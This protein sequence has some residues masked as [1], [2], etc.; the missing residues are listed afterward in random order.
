MSAQNANL[1]TGLQDENGTRYAT[2]THDWVGHATGSSLNGGVGSYSFSFPSDTARTIVDPLGVSRT[3]AVAKVTGHLRYTASP[4]VCGGCNEASS[5]SYDAY[6]NLA[7]STDFN[8]HVSTYAYDTTRSLETSRTE[9]SGTS[10]AR[11]ITT[12]WATNFREPLSVSVYAGGSA[13]G[14]PLRTT[15]FTY[16]GSGNALTKTVTDTTVAP[17]VSRTWTYTYDS[18][19]HVLTADGPRT[20]VL[21]KTTY[22]YYSCTSGY[23]CGQLHTVTDAAGNVTTY[24]TYNAYGQ[25]LTLTDANGTTIMGRLCRARSGSKPGKA[26]FPQARRA[27]AWTA[28]RTRPAD[29]CFQ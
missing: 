22:T 21:D 12:S 16:D 23:Q 27:V 29:P 14:T 25:P 7:S 10:R 4:S 3:Y 5:Q 13:S 19:G 11:T 8:G 18:Y 15:S 28:S 2:W 17:N 26:A 9:A 20:D 6:G 1:L 24:L